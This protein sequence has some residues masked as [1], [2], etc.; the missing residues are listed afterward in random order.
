VVQ[1]PPEVGDIFVLGEDNA[2]RTDHHKHP[3]LKVCDGLHPR[4]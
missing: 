1:L 3:H 2:V 4:E